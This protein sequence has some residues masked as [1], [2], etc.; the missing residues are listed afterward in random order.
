MVFHKMSTKFEMTIWGKRPEIFGSL[1]PDI[2]F[3][4]EKEPLAIFDII[5]IQYPVVDTLDPYH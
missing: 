2:D 3:K 1:F 5:L 4:I